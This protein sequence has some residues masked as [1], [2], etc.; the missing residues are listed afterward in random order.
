MRNAV[1]PIPSLWRVGTQTSL[2]VVEVAWR[3]PLVFLSSWDKERANG[4]LRAALAALAHG[5]E[6]AAEV[7]DRAHA[8]HLGG[9]RPDRR[10]E[11][12]H[13]PLWHALCVRYFKRWAVATA[14]PPTL[15][16]TSWRRR[17]A[18]FLAPELRYRL[19]PAHAQ[20]ASAS[21]LAVSREAAGAGSEISAVGVWGV[22]M[23]MR[24]RHGLRARGALVSTPLFEIQAA[25][26]R[27]MGRSKNAR[28][29]SNGK[30]YLFARKPD[31][32]WHRLG[33]GRRGAG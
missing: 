1:R 21:Q 16:I 17:S 5:L 15:R 22:S 20:R 27:P 6:V 25:Y 19:G 26:R 9:P 10:R 12:P 4:N 13:L 14:T 2:G 32:H 3:F 23:S 30:L 11:A 33:M 31:H 8:A 18:R 29:R 24:V 28:S 7:R